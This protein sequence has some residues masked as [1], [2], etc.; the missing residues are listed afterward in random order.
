MF[1]KLAPIG[2]MAFLCINRRHRS[3]SYLERRN[4]VAGIMR[5]DRSA[6]CRSRASASLR[7]N[8]SR[9]GAPFLAPGRLSIATTLMGAS[10]N[11]ASLRANVRSIAYEFETGLKPVA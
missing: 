10:F 3:M 2:T 1:E 6:K 5:A 9:F 7:Q 11:F 8:P 4:A